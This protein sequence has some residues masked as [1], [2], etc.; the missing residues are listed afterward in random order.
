MPKIS[1]VVAFDLDGTLIDSAPDI[2]TA[3]N[4]VLEQNGLKK[5]NIKNVRKLIGNGAKNLINESFLKQGRVSYDIENLTNSFL[6]KYKKCFKDKTNL[7]PNAKNVLETLKCKKYDIVLVSNKPEYYSK[8]LLKHFQINRYFSYIAGGDTFKYRKPDARHLKNTIEC[9]KI[10][11]YKTIFVGD[12]NFDL[13]CAN[14]SNI[15]CILLSHGYS[16]IDIRELNAYKVV[17]NLK[18]IIDIID[19]YFE[20]IL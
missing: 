14:N 5:V 18:Y 6:N 11:N 1:K 19:D 9:S 13:E 20:N 12:S 17:K 3:L 7:F 16:D 10:V 8:A 4:Y 2:T 15:P